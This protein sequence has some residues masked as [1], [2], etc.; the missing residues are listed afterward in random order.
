MSWWDVLGAGLNLA[1]GVAGASAAESAAKTQAKAQREAGA[2]LRPY[3]ELGD[4]AAGE[5]RG[6]LN[7]NALLKDFDFTRKD[8]KADPGYQFRLEEGNKA[9]DRAAGARGGRYSGATLKALQRFGQDYA[10]NEY[11]RA[12]QRA[13]DQDANNRTMQ[14]NFLA[15]PINAGQGASATIG[16]Y[17]SN[18]GDARAAGQVGAANSLF[19]GAADAYNVA[20]TNRYLRNNPYAYLLPGGMR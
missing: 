14:Y 19:G 4:Y 10:S 12:Y 3:A 20:N 11:G 9:I 6:R 2:Q 15:G 16:N 17:M 1:A 5:M 13:F 7:R 8:F 18:A